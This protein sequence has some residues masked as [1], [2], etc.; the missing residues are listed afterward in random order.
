M[1]SKFLKYLV[2][3]LTKEPLTLQNA[4]CNGEIIEGG[5]LTS[6]KSQYPIE[7]GVPRFAGYKSEGYVDSFGYEWNKWSR[8]QFE[9]ENVNKPMEGHTLR[10]WERITEMETGIAGQLVLD[11]GCGAGRFID[12]GRKKGARVIGIDYSGAVDVASENFRDDP[13]VCICQAD[14]LN[15]PL[16]GLTVDGAFSIGVLHHTPNPLSGV[17]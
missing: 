8:V 15:L 7:N 17:V 1:H 10:M 4:I 3:P 11:I 6:T 14:A 13:D 9:S 16:S 5:F 2:D 12:L